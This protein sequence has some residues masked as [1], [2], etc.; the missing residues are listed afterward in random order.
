[1]KTCEQ[2]A[3]LL[4]ALAEEVLAPAEAVEVRAH[5]GGCAACAESW[6]IQELI[7]R[8]IRET[9]LADRP[10]YFWAKQRK[11]ILDEVGI[12]TSRFERAGAPRRRF[13]VP[14]I[15]A[16]AA[17][18]LIAV[19]FAIFRNP[20]PQ[21]S[22][23][24]SIANQPKRNDIPEDVTKPVPDVVQPGPEEKKD[25]FAKPVEPPKNPEMPPPPLG[26]GEDK[27]VVKDPPPQ[28]D[29]KKDD[30]VKEPKPKDKTT[31]VAPKPPSKPEDVA[32]LSGHAKY[33]FRLA[34]EQV[35]IYVPLDALKTP[36]VKDRETDEQVLAILKSGRA[37][38]DD[39]RL[40]LAKD[41]KADVTEMVD[42]YALLV[43][44]GAG[45]ILF[46]GREDRTFP[47]SKTEL[48]AQEVLLKAFP[49]D[50]RK[51]VLA[52]A[53]LAHA[54][55]SDS[56]G[57]PHKV[58]AGKDSDSGAYAAAR[59]TV[60]F[61]KEPAP[62]AGVLPLR[63]KFGFGSASRYQLALLAHA[64]EGRVPESEAD[65]EAYQMMV[66]GMVDMLGLLDS[67]DAARVCSQARSYLNEFLGRFKSYRGPEATKR[68]IESAGHY[69][70][71]MIKS[72]ADLELFFQNKGPKPPK[73]DP[74]PPPQGDPP[75][76]N[77]PPPPA[78]PF[79]ETPPP[80]P[81]PPPP[82]PFGED[83]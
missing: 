60:M 2:A 34:E 76:S 35:N 47:R 48:R 11:H 65:F 29:K 69:T 33:P 1:M 56:R 20:D 10:D 5:I 66:D 36:V 39:I 75:A 4:P 71:A 68:V 3:E 32:I 23:G 62:S 55:A 77:P 14:M 25:E 19:T 81:P 41:P 15:A 74:A 13:L 24:R 40:M 52:A 63:T 46:K 30:V 61:I 22:N 80:S 42:A 7:S 59:E 44:E 8:H 67:K 38:L 12:G 50:V 9:D 26:E 37:R 54:A 6:R 51:G 17:A 31:D 64:R 21:P 58:R 43:G 82:P 73:R 27:K 18:V 83:P 78:P 49:D 45:V 16:A 53:V 28:P 72:V 70:V 57:R 79:G